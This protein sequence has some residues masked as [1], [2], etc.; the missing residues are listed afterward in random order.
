MV[1]QIPAGLDAEGKLPRGGI[2]MG[3]RIALGR[4]TD[5]LLVDVEDGTETVLAS[6]AGMLCWSFA[7]DGESVVFSARGPS[8]TLDIL[9]LLPGETH[10][11]PIV[12]TGL[13]EHSPALS[14]DGRW[15]A[16]VARALS[17]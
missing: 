13:E 7:A 9:G 5:L 10:P 1:R 15:I 12:A 4:D 8:G 3:G 14:P 6:A 17:S 16:Y 11:Q 2:L